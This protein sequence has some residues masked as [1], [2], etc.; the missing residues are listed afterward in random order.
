[1]P[2][3]PQQIL[4]KR[5]LGLLGNRRELGGGARRKGIKERMGRK[6]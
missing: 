1:M 3:S 4:P 5:E 2:S 6:V